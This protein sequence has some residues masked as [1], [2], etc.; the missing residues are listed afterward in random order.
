ME[1][2][3]NCCKNL[4]KRNT[5]E[6]ETQVIK[7]KVAPKELT[8]TGELLNDSNKSQLT[9][10]YLISKQPPGGKEVPF[11]V[12]TFKATYVQPP[13]RKFSN[14]QPGLQSSAR[15][16]FTAR[17]AD[18]LGTSFFPYN[19]ESIFHQGNML[20]YI[21]PGSTRRNQQRNLPQSTGQ[22]N[23]QRR[24]SSTLD[25]NA[26][27]GRTQRIDSLCSTI[28][29]TS[30]ERSLESIALSGDEQEL[31][32]VCVRL[33]YQQDVEQVWITLVQCSDLCVR[34]DEEQKIGIKAIIT[35]PKPIHFKTSL[36]EYHQDVTIMETF[37]FALRLQQ[38]Q[39]SALVLQLQTNNPR[40]RTVAEC[41]LSLQQLS[42]EETEHWL[43]LKQP[44]KS[45]VCNSELH[46]STL[47]Q[48]VSGRIQLK[49]LEAKN[50]P[51][52]SSP[53][54]QVFF[55]KVEMQQLGQGAIKKKT[56]AL[57]ASSGKCRW[58][59]T[60]PFLLASLEHA[61]LLSLRLYSCN[62]VR[63]KQCLG[64]VQLGFDSP[65]PAAVEQWKETMAH[66]EKVVTAWHRLSPT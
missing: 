22:I 5:N 33:R 55:V 13:N 62:S 45:S 9:Q 50:L 28:S 6:Q 1:F 7:M 2:L 40:K 48:P 53:L 35:V 39:R 58:D 43:D 46:I 18:L 26:P 54:P 10:D 42:A 56:Q 27:Q 14:Q 3:K 59:E 51:P 37:V 36:K 41:V 16:T 34:P 17:K 19:S 49:V 61:C 11:V 8:A 65:L 25:L 4:S 20:A 31:G 47:F 44:S 23:Q 52:S 29:S 21:S 60:F 15:S 64:Q 57:K 24:S 12:P 63:R 66:P 32:K 30:M 38:L